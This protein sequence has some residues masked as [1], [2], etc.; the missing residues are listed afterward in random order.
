MSDSDGPVKIL[1]AQ[2]CFA[3]LS[4][5]NFGRLVVRRSDDMDVF[6]LNFIVDDGFLYFRTA[7]GSKL[8]SINLNHDV[9]LE[10]DEVSED[11]A[12]SVVVRGKAEIV[13]GT[14]NIAHA[15]SLPLKPWVP[16]LKY[17]YVR[18]A[19]SEISGREFHLGQ[20]PERY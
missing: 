19:P 16:T 6:P 2:D 9:L 18:I 13:R 12:W 11:L 17:N 10:A 8:F 14:E 1:S 4:S 20:E 7:E 5:V 3:R 15:D